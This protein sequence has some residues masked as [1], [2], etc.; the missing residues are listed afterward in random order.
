MA[1]H[2]MKQVTRVSQRAIINNTMLTISPTL[3]HALFRARE[4]GVRQYRLARQLR[5]HP[6][7]LSHLVNGSVPVRENDPR[8]LK[9]AEVLGVPAD[10]A[11]ERLPEHVA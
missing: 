8:V 7:L 6:S 1:V 4:N 9:L 11:F 3:R 5:I 2:I 10:Q